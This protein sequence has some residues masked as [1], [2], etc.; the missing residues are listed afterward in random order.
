MTLQYVKGFPGLR[1]RGPGRDPVVDTGPEGQAELERFYEA[2]LGDDPAFF[3]LEPERAKGFYA[4]AA[5]VAA[6]RPGSLRFIKGHITGPVT[7]ASALKSPDGREILYDD[8]FR[9]VVAAFM[10]GC[11]RWQVRKLAGLGAP[12]ILFLDEPVM[13]VYGSAYSSAL[14]RELVE[15]LWAPS[16]E[17]IRAEGALSGIHCCGN[18]DWGFLFSVGTDIV[19]FDAFHFLD[20]MLLYPEDAARFLSGGGSLAWGIV[21]TS[22]EA[23]HENGGSLTRRL[24]EGFERFAAEGVDAGLL[25]SQCLLTPSCGMGSLAPELAEEILRLLEEVSLRVRL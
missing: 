21:P 1:E 4:F 25:R 3:A 12:V 23:R 13:E 2:V 18:T 7:L 9:E 11:A 10:A 6:S 19:N 16:L 8:T 22:E 24:E 14:T 17:A 5:R 15:A 20:R